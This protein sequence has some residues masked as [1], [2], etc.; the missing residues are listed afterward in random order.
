[1]K[2]VNKKYNVK[3]SVNKKVIL[4]SDLHY[5]NKEDIDR[6]NYILEN[7]SLQEPDYICI[8]GD[9]ID[10]SAILDEEDIIN[11]LKKLSLVAKTIISIGNHEFYINKHNKV[12][13]LNKEFFKKVS[14]INNL[15]LLDNDNISIDGINFI[16]LTVPMDLYYKTNITKE[17]NEL[18]NRLN[19]INDKFNILLCHSPELIFNKSIL[20][21]R[22]INLILC[23]HMHGGAVPTFLRKIFGH[24]GIISPRKKLF[25]KYSY[26]K[27]DNMIITS[28][29]KVIPKGKFTNVF[30]PEVV[31][32][33]LTIK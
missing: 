1:M 9:L 33:Y 8:C 7:I 20:N 25:P 29:I 10:K 17:M 14:S 16:G 31:R 19:F 22:N 21:N 3:S 24:R 15:Y 28:G 32:I 26:G 30:R 18:L 23:G 2:I 13:G 27:I 6:L 4:I 12:F 11:W 5:S